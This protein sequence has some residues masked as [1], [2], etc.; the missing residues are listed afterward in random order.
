MPDFFSVYVLTAA[1]LASIVRH[2]NPIPAASGPT[3]GA[4]SGNVMNQD[5]FQALSD[6][7]EGL[8][9]SH[10]RALKENQ[11]LRDGERGWRDERRQLLE[12]HRNAKSRLES[13]LLR[14]KALDNS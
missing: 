14:L 3:L 11:A 5:Q 1:Y 12:K 6:K 4:T 2:Y 10:S 8:I 7:V 9:E 13:L